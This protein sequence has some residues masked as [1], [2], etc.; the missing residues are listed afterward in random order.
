MELR[1]LLI[2]IQMDQQIARVD[3]ATGFKGDLTHD[4]SQVRADGDAVQSC[5][6]SDA[7]KCRLPLRLFRNF[8]CDRGWRRLERTGFCQRY[9]ALYLSKFDKS[10]AEHKRPEQD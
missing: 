1:F 2:R 10:E 3:S 4:S 6:G 9:K 5:D 8:R 7:L